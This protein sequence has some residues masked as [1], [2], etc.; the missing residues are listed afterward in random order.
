MQ[1]IAAIIPARYESTRLAHKVLLDIGGKPMLQHVV[2]RVVASQLFSNVIVATDHDSIYDF[3]MSHSIKAYMTSPFH[4]SGTERIAEVA[5]HIDASIIVNVQADEP[6]VTLDQL[7]AISGA[8]DEANVAIATLSCPFS[9]TNALFDY[10]KVKVV[11][12]QNEDALYF[13]RQ[14]IPAM[15]DTPYRKW[16]ASYP[17]RKHIGIYGYRKDTLLKL[18]NLSSSKLEKIESLEQLRWLDHGYKIRV[19]EVSSDS[20]GVDTQED[21]DKAREIYKKL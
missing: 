4:T 13:S 18:V 16:S 9:D 20:F 12:N 17:Y 21:L 7:E 5:E 14:V 3:C 10:N 11:T 2:E 19:V 1:T 6:F 8:F 15:R